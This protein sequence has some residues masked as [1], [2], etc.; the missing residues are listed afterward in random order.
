M[1]R[2]GETS[3]ATGALPGNNN[4]VEV[5]GAAN[6]S[7]ATAATTSGVKMDI[8]AMSAWAA[9]LQQPEYKE[10]NG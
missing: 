2:S 9:A 6:S 10:Y 8:S 1:G 7:A 4:N 3:A 5:T